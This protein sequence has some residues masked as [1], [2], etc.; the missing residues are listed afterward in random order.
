MVGFGKR[1][2]GKVERFTCEQD[3]YIPGKLLCLFPL[4]YESEK[5]NPFSVLM[6]RRNKQLWSLSP[7][8]GRGC[9]IILPNGTGFAKLNYFEGDN[10]FST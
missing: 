8:T 4:F 5:N 1:T 7:Y 10:I 6:A 9:F 2:P 3:L